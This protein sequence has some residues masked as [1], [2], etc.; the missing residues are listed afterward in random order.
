MD[1][2]QSRQLLR[3]LITLIGITATVTGLFVVLT[4]SSGQVDGS[5]AP[6]SV[7]SELRFFAVFWIAYGVAALRTAPR[8][9]QETVAVRAL[10]LILFGGGI[11]RSI[12]WIADGRPH[13]LFI[14]LLCL[15]L[16]LPALM[17]VLQGRLGSERSPEVGG[18]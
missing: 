9:D 4:G 10:A 11:A 17:L 18:G 8:A 2:E 12:A 14:V 15:E 3:V 5:Q 1:R 16:L 7:E 13:A 6:P